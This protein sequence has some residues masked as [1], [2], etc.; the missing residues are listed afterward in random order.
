MNSSDFLDTAKT[1]ARDEMIQLWRGPSFIRFFRSVTDEH[2]DAAFQALAVWGRS[3]HTELTDGFAVAVSG[4]STTVC[5]AIRDGSDR[6]IHLI[7]QLASF[8]HVENGVVA[9]SVL[10]TFESFLPGLQIFIIDQLIKVCIQS[11]PPSS[12]MCMS[13]PGMAFKLLF[14]LDPQFKHWPQLSAARD[15]CVLGC[16]GWASQEH[17]RSSHYRSVGERISRY[18][19]SDT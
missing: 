8:F 19:D 6:Q 9:F 15:Q 7:R 2:T 17:A 3:R 1:A 16:N 12:R 18:L 13:V 4:A 11:S 14:D 5:R 10:R